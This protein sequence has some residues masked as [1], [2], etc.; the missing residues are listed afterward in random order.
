MPA[1]DSRFARW[2]EH[3]VP[4]PLVMLGAALIAWEVAGAVPQW[5]VQGAVARPLAWVLVALGVGFGIAGLWVFRRAGTTFDPHAP[6]RTRVL[7]TTGPYRFTRNPMYLGLALVLLAW[8][9]WLANPAALVG[10]LL[11]V[12]YLT[13]FQI[14][15]E[16]RVMQEK[17]GAEYA[18]YRNRVRRWL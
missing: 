2:L 5:S 17:F 1:S 8:C 11:F 4:P 15:P 9:A 13:R 10:V 18:S 7:V 12:A 3:R 14:I 16:E 6:Q